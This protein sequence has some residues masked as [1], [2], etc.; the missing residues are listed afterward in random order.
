M[1]QITRSRPGPL[2]CK[3]DTHQVLGD[4]VGS[5]AGLGDDLRSGQLTGTCFAQETGG[6]PVTGFGTWLGSGE[7]C[8][9]Y[10]GV[11]SS[12]IPDGYDD[13]TMMRCICEMAGKSDPVVIKAMS[14]GS[15]RGLT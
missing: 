9:Q 2:S 10:G 15:G 5:G 7:G 3:Y 6:E 11:L 4:G 8:G 12:R 1:G 14:P 13:G